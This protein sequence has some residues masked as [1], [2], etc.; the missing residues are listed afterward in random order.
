MFVNKGSV[1]RQM[2]MSYLFTCGFVCPA[3]CMTFCYSRLLRRTYRQLGSFANSQIR[4]KEV[5]S[6]ARARQVSQKQVVLSTLAVVCFYYLLWTP[7]WLVFLTFVV[8]FDMPMAVK[9]FSRVLPYGSSALNWIFYALCNRQVC[10][11]FLYNQIS[12]A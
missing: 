11:L 4:M 7:Y 12:V 3:I 6:I 10:K 1:I 9:Q 8:G 2:L 5:S